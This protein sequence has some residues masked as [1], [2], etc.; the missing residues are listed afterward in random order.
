MATNSHPPSPP[1][2]MPFTAFPP[3]PPTPMTFKTACVLGSTNSNIMGV[4]SLF[5][6]LFFESGIARDSR[7]RR[8]FSTRSGGHH[9]PRSNPGLSPAVP[10]EIGWDRRLDEAREPSLLKE[11]PEPAANRPR[12]A[13]QDRSFG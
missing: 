7:H 12:D 4:P 10:I 5:P 3:A 2:T 9:R 11:L 13:T 8:S 6:C 1:W